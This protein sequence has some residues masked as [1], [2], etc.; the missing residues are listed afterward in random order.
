MRGARRT[1]ARPLTGREIATSQASERAQ[2]IRERRDWRE[3]NSVRRAHACNPQTSRRRASRR[4]LRPSQRRSPY[5]GMGTT[6]LAEKMGKQI[7]AGFQ[8]CISAATWR[9]PWT[10][11]PRKLYAGLSKAE[12]T[13]LFLMRTEV[14]GLNAWLAAIQV[15]GVTPTCPPCGWQAQTVR[16]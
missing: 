16:S 10:Q 12:S 4:N 5:Q 1:Q 6:S 14:I 15:P 11:D 9:T 3:E 7:L 13:A 2:E 8:P